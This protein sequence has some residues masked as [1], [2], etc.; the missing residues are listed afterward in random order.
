MVEYSD[1]VM[2]HGS[3]VKMVEYLDKVMEQSKVVV[4]VLTEVVL[5]E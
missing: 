2:E 3:V 1:K 4:T 5:M